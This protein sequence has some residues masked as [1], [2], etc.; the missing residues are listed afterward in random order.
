MVVDFGMSV[1]GPVNL[2]ANSEMG[3]FGNMEWYEGPQISPAMQV[4]VDNEV[5]KII[6]HAYREAEIIIKKNRKTLDAI[7]KKLLDKETLDKDEFEK[8]VGRKVV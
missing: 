3:D 8:I 1:L 5:S 2:G 4:K 7:V 6:E